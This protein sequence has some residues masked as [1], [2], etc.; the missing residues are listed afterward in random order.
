M[1]NEDQVDYLIRFLVD[2][3]PF[4]QRL[5]MYKQV[6]KYQGFLAKNDVNPD[7]PG[8][9]ALAALTAHYS[10]E[11]EL[12]YKPRQLA[13]RCLNGAER[14]HGLV[15]HAVNHMGSL[16]GAKPGRLSAGWVEPYHDEQ[17]INCEKC[18]KR[19]SALRELLPL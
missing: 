13:G 17:Q 10:V 6:R 8:I 15:I 7:F 3:M 16:C 19:I 5:K 12:E 2:N 9:G 14:D 18:T 11:R 4:A 1:L